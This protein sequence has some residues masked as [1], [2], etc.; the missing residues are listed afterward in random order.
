MALTAAATDARRCFLDVTS[1]LTGK[2]WEER[3][4]DGRAAMALAQRVGAPEIVGRILA[5]RGVGLEAVESFLNPRL[6]DL[7]PDPLLLRDMDAAVQRLIAALSAGEAIAIFGDYD[8]D[9]ATSTAL[10]QRFLRAVGGKVSAYIPDRIVEGYGPNTPALLGLQK[11]GVKVV[12]TVDCGA[13]AYG[14]LED[15]RAA[16]LDVI[17][18]DHHAMEAR[19]PPATALVNP[20]RLDDDSPHGNLAAVGVAFLLVVA[21]NRALREAGHYGDGKRSE[22][23][24]L[25]WLD[26]VALGTVCDVV[27]LVGLNRAL[28]T[29]GLK[30]VA[31]RRNCGIAA[32]CDIAQI[33]ETPDSYHLGYLLGPRI[34]AGGRVGE[35]AL[36][37]D[38]LSLD[39]P[40][41]AKD[42]ARR[43]DGYNQERR[44]IES[45]VLDQAIAQ[46]EA[47]DRSPALVLAAGEGW[48]PGVIGI[49]ASRLKDRYN[50][51]AFVIALEGEVG[52]GSGRSL[53]GVD[54]GALV[55]AARG[56]GLLI[57]GGGH[58]M[59]AGITLARERLADFTAF[60]R[61]KVAQRLATADLRPTL[62]FDGALQPGGVTPEL[63]RQIEA[64][65]P[66][67]AG[68]PQ[69]R[70]ALTGARLQHKAVVGGNHLRCRVTGPDGGRLN[71][72]AFR[73][74]DSPLGDALS[75]AGG[76][77][78]HLAGKIK[79]DAWR[80]PDAVQF[81][82]EDAAPVSP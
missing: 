44:E 53:P 29:Q 79:R 18:I 74:F 42:I 61:E 35:A 11:A 27:P 36:G 39:N 2:R 13:T 38:L 58:P 12:V 24:L 63:L 30:I 73:A 45:Q 4:S 8:V 9:G 48:H 40:E 51:P 71:A 82:I 14:P 57:N 49:V 19:L 15:A 56:E 54:L 5:A 21:L 10:L 7:L 62:G 47:S 37:A 80:G 43:L 23:D 66:Y 64:C 6:R 26:L 77:P 22:P 59:A 55:T 78:L 46:V 75:Q 70:F 28:V 60:V 1:S 31:Q 72:I 76:L 81:I 69:P 25:Q 33:S 32:L 50:R 17:V 20:N 41:D 67:G 3:L 34:N 16:G 52:K 65:G 68:N